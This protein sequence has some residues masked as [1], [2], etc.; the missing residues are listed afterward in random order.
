MYLLVA[1]LD[2]DL[3]NDEM[4][5]IGNFVAKGHGH[6]AHVSCRHSFVPLIGSLR[7]AVEHDF[8]L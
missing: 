3:L 4:E 7:V 1:S 5:A 2:S 6:W 8:K